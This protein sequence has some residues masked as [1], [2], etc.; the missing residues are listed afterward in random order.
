MAKPNY[1]H[2]KKQREETKKREKQKKLTKRLGDR[3]SQVPPKAE[4]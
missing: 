1:R 3:T 4:P 2:L